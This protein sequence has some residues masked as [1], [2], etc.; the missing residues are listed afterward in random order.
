MQVLQIEAAVVAAVL[1]AILQMLVQNG[2]ALLQYSLQF[3]IF[4]CCNG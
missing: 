2:C 3:S 1:G 4:H